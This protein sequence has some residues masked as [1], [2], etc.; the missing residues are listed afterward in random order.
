MAGP[1]ASMHRAYGITIQVTMPELPTRTVQQ[2]A[3]HYISAQDLSKF[4]S[5][6]MTD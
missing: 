3:Y 1:V 4:L 6:S 5:I 2:F